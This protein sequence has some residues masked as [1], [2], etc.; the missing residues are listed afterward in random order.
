MGIFDHVYVSWLNVLVERL[1]TLDLS[2]HL[3]IAIIKDNIKRPK[4]F[5]NVGQ[6]YFVRLIAYPY[7]NSV[8]GK[9]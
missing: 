9:L 7:V 2:A 8:L 4:L 5:S 1:E 6:K 3:M